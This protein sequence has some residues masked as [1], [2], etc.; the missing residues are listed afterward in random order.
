MSVFT[1]RGASSSSM[2]LMNSSTRF[3]EGEGMQKPRTGSRLSAGFSA[4]GRCR[5]VASSRQSHFLTALMVGVSLCSETQF[6]RRLAS[7]F[8]GVFR[9]DNFAHELCCELGVLVCEFDPDSFAIHHGQLVAQLVTRV[10][11]VTDLVHGSREIV[12]VL[13]RLASDEAVDSVHAGDPAVRI[14]VKLSAEVRSEEHTS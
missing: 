12:I 9:P 8:L 7:R 2:N 4:A 10:T 1:E 3:A 13:V 6:L 14:E 11:V 5:V